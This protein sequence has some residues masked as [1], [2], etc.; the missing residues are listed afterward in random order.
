MGA[1]G[2]NT[3]GSSSVGTNLDY[4]GSLICEGGAGAGGADSTVAGG[5]GLMASQNMSQ[6]NYK[7]TITT[8]FACETLMCHKCVRSQQCGKVGDPL[9]G[10]KY[11]KTWNEEK[12]NCTDTQ[13]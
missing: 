12:E 4:I 2:A 7:E 3:A 11:C 5:G 9:F 10:S 6:Y 8:T 1:L 13:F